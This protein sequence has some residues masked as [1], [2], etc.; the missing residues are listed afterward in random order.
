[1]LFLLSCHHL[2]LYH[3]I[4]NKRSVIQ[5]LQEYE[6]SI[7]SKLDCKHKKDNI[8]PAFCGQIILMRSG[9]FSGP[10]RSSGLSH[11]CHT[12]PFQNCSFALLG[13]PLSCLTCCLRSSFDCHVAL[14]PSASESKSASAALTTPY[15]T[16]FL[17]MPA[18]C[19]DSND[20]EPLAR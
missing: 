3:N 10:G 16:R 11:P 5:V 18:F 1:M 4:S 6:T 2:L 13:I 15:C 19:L 17:A 20:D 8:I 7:F 14:K 9:S 12:P